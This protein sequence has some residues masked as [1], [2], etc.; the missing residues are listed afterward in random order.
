MGG[1]LGEERAGQ[2][3]ATAVAQCGPGAAHHG[4]RVRI[5]ARGQLERVQVNMRGIVAVTA[6]R[7]P[8]CSA[9]GP[10]AAGC[11]QGGGSPEGGH[12]SAYVH[13]TSKLRWRRCCSTSHCRCRRGRGTNVQVHRGENVHRRR[14]AAWHTRSAAPSTLA[15]SLACITLRGMGAAAS[16]CGRSLT[17]LRLTLA[18]SSWARTFCSAMRSARS[19]SSTVPAGA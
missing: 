9:A 4:R 8:W 5:Q 12:T 1:Y 14:G 16:R 3:Q 17:V 6:H 7:E 10:A 2:G 15:H 13:S 19:A 18:M 11:Q